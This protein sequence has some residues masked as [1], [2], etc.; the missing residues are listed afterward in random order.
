MRDSKIESESSEEGD[1]ALMAL[2]DGE[3]L[4]TKKHQSLVNTTDVAEIMELYFKIQQ[5]FQLL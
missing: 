1:Y 5:D 3:T 4:G 2:Q